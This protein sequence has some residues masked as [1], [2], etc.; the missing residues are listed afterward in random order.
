MTGVIHLGLSEAFYNKSGS[1]KAMGNSFVPSAVS[2]AQLISHILAGKAWTQ[3]YFNGR[4]RTKV[5]WRSGQTLALDLDKGVVTFETVLA[6]SFIQTYALFVHHTTRSTP[7]LHKLRVIFVLDTPYTDLA[8]WERLQKALM[9]RFRDWQPDPAPKDAARLFFGSAGAEH[10]QAVDQ[11]LPAEVATELLAAFDAA[12]PK[13]QRPDLNLAVRN[14]TSSSLMPNPSQAATP[15][16]VR[17]LLATLPDH[18]DDYN[19]WLRCLLAARAALGEDQALTVLAEKWPDS[20]DEIAYKFSTFHEDVEQPVTLGSLFHLA[21]Q[22]GWQP[23]RPNYAHLTAIQADRTIDVQW[24]SEGVTSLAKKVTLIKSP[25]GMGKTTLALKVLPGWLGANTRLLYVSPYTSLS[26]S[27]AKKYDL[28]DYED[29]GD[30][31]KSSHR[32]GITLASLYKLRDPQFASLPKW[33]LL[34]L[35]ESELLL[36]QLDSAIF[37]GTNEP[38][39]QGRN[40]EADQVLRGLIRGASYV[41]FLDAYMTDLSRWYAEE[42][43]GRDQ[44]EVVV[45]THKPQR[46]V[47]LEVES[48]AELKALALARLKAP[49]RTLP[50]VYLDD[51]KSSGEAVAR[52]AEA[53]GFQV[54][55]VN[56]DNSRQDEVREVLNTLD[57]RAADYDLIVASPTLAAGFDVQAKVDNLYLASCGNTLGAEGLRQFRG[58]F[59]EVQ[60][61]VFFYIPDHKH[62]QPSYAWLEAQALHAWR[63]TQGLLLRGGFSISAR[64]DADGQLVP[65]EETRQTLALQC[66]VRAHRKRGLSC[67]RSNYRD[68]AAA[69][70][71]TLGAVDPANLPPEVEVAQLATELKEERQ[72]QRE[73]REAAILNATVPAYAHPDL[74]FELREKDPAIAWR[75]QIEQALGVDLE[76]EPQALQYWRNGR[77]RDELQLLVALGYEEKEALQRDFQQHLHGLSLANLD[78]L[79]QKW[80]LLRKLFRLTYGDKRDLAALLSVEDLRQRGVFAFLDERQADFQRLFRI[81]TDDPIQVLKNLHKQVGLRLNSRQVRVDGKREYHYQLDPQR[82]ADMRRYATCVADPIHA[83]WRFVLDP[84]PVTPP[85]DRQV[86]VI[87]VGEVPVQVGA[88]CLEFG[89]KNIRHLSLLMPNSSQD[90]PFVPAQ[91]LPPGGIHA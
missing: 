80:W 48:V 84:E 45:N 78:H 72:R 66:R 7:E 89:S 70:G 41:V 88:A 60:G 18:L 46:P 21:Q 69:D 24:L 51:S 4:S 43:V 30:R 1:K 83:R 49:A 16:Q 44:L 28:D 36:Q 71:V 58:R 38:K 29:L 33:D 52:R 63:T 34:V 62:G 14:K 40:V 54:F 75:Y 50:V 2:P 53:D 22:H 56:S 15:D 35:D 20:R 57:D 25:T 13:K 91:G 9:W 85:V 8:A 74:I 67:L 27:T 32:L 87:I 79:T 5:T 59:R 77:G 23:S 90:M 19:D 76:K 64:Y 6:D 42:V 68:L 47:E 39:R 3:G 55:L 31:A 73:Q 81:R 37:S 17:E 10:W 65:S 11:R 82:L 12:H 61:Q 86:D 26:K